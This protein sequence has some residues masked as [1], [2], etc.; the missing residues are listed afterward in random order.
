MGTTLVTTTGADHPEGI[1]GD[2]YGNIYI[3]GHNYNQVRKFTPNYSNLT[4]VAGAS[5]CGKSNALPC[6]DEPLGIA[7]DDSLNIYVAERASFRVSKWTLG[8]SAGTTVISGSGSIG[9]YGIVLSRLYSNRAFV[10]SEESDRVY[11]WQFNVATPAVTLTAVNGTP[12]TLLDP[13]GLAGDDYGNLYVVDR[14]NNRIVMYC[15]NSTLGRVVA[16]GPGSTPA[17]N[18]PYS[19]ALDSNLNLFVVDKGANTVVKYNRI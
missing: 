15:E 10:S 3:A 11:L 2:K 1:T 6:L 17:L 14:S 12:N 5:G 7:V 8:S 16:G 4:N 9:F 18:D 19:V 13:R